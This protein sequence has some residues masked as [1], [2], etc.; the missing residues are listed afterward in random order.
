M[1]S[2]KQIKEAIEK[3]LITIL[4][5]KRQHDMME[6]EDEVLIE[7][8]MEIE[9][10]PEELSEFMN[11]SDVLEQGEVDISEQEVEELKTVADRIVPVDAEFIECV[12]SGETR[13][14]IDK[15]NCN[16]KHVP[17]LGVTLVSPSNVLIE[18]VRLDSDMEDEGDIEV[19]LMLE[20]ES[21]KIYYL[22]TL[23]DL[24]NQGLIVTLPMGTNAIE[25]SPFEFRGVVKQ[26][27]KAEMEKLLYSK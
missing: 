24:T 17:L 25:M 1:D 26:S 8:F 10:D 7:P 18:K 27:D 11:L 21:F 4:E 14:L 9:V 20:T 3:A 6:E 19:H 13:L 2:K 22:F 23:E 15:V 5:K 12:V 16:M